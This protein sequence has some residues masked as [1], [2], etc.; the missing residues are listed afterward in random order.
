V[1]LKRLCLADD[2]EPSPAE[3]EFRALSLAREHGVPVPQPL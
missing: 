2:D 3:S 1:V